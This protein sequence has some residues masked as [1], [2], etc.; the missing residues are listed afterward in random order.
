MGHAIIRGNTV[1]EKLASANKALMQL[2]RRIAARSIVAP[3]TPMIMSGYCKEDDGGIIAR[4]MIPVSGFITKV[5]LYIEAI[6]DVE[7]L[8]KNVLEFYI[9]SHQSDGMIINKQFK[10][11]KTAIGEFTSFKIL[12]E[13]RITVSINTK[14][15]GIW[16]S[17]V[18]E[19]E[20][21]IKRKVDVSGTDD[22]LESETEVEE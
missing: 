21:P 5:S 14:A 4:V 12:S 8:K 16:Y 1:D 15:S 13:S 2:E 18:L 9:E 6:E 17:I 20:V 22:L 3:L 19:P 10:T 11:K 7:F